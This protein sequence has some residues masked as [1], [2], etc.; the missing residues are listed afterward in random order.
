[1]YTEGVSYYVI[2]ADYTGPYKQVYADLFTLDTLYINDTIIRYD[3]RSG[4]GYAE[5]SVTHAMT[6]PI[7]VEAEVVALLESDVYVHKWMYRQGDTV[8]GF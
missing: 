1:M 8:D 7:R 3:W 2:D 5:D 6:D 4:L